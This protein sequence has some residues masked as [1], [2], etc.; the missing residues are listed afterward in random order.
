M[1]N[2]A[3]N[4]A[5]TIIRDFETAASEPGWFAQNDGVM[6]G[7]SKGGSEVSNGTLLFTGS[8]SLANNGG[9]AQVYSPTV[10]TDLSEYRSVVLRVRGDGRTYQFR[11][12]TNARYRG[13]RI[14]YRAEFSTE[15]GEWQELRIPFER[16]VPS[17]RGR[18]LTGPELDTRSVQQIALLLADG[19]AGPFRLEVDWIGW[20]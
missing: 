12:A 2:G 3:Q 5:L 13:S 16:F 19:Q 4:T 1:T 14:A 17:Y 9:F 11:L 15:P 18:R 10:K 6:G 20:K 8:I 7:V